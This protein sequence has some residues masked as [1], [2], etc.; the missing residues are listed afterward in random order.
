MT[1]VWKYSTGG[2]RPVRYSGFCTRLLLNIRANS[3]SN[4]KIMRILD[5]AHAA[6][7]VAPVGDCSKAMTRDC[8]ES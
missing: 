1:P 7:I 5:A 8:F 3:C 6:S 4:Y 2:A